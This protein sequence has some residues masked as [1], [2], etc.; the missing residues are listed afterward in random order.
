MKSVRNRT[1]IVIV[2]VFLVFCSEFKPIELQ[3]HEEHP[4]YVH[5]VAF[6]SGHRIHL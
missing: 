3:T 2:P 1:F 5:S 6:S 4:D